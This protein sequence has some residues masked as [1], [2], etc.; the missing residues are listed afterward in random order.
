MRLLTKLFVAFCIGTVLAQG[1][2]LAMAAARGN[3]NKVT[4]FKAIALLNGVDITGDQLQEMLDK[5][6]QTPKPTYEDIEWERA[7]QSKSLDMRERSILQY[8]RQVDE[9]LSEH[10]LVVADFD[11]RKNEFYRFLETTQQ[12]LSNESLKELQRTLEILS[13]ELAK[14]QL[15]TFLQDDKMDDVVAVVKGM[16]LDKRKKV[17]GQ[18][19]TPEETAKLNE[20]LSTLRRGDP[21]AGLIEK[22][23]AENAFD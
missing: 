18:F 7:T 6:K 4:F 12:N 17:L 14:D 1:I 13:P 11:R 9:L 23:R 21:K 8:K 3:L 16:P 15:I 20:I 2:V 5:S 19:T 22:A 10:K